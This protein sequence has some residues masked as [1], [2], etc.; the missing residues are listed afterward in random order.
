MMA[1]LTVSPT[2]YE[3]VDI[4]AK[5]INITYTCDKTLTDVKLSID[6]GSAY[7]NNDSM[8]QTSAMFNID[9]MANDDYICKLK[10]YYN[11]DQVPSIP[12][13][14]VALDKS[15]YTFTDYTT[16]Q[17][18][19]TVYP[20][21]A[22]NKNIT[23]SSSN[24]SV[25][26][27]NSDGLVT[28]V[29]NGNV[30]ITTTT[31]DGGKTSTCY[32]TVNKVSS[33]PVLSVALD[34]SS[35]TFTDYT[36]LQL[37]A[38]IYPS[39]ATNKNVSWT[40]SNSS[41]ATVDGSGLVTAKTNGNTTITVTTS[42]GDKTSTCSITVNKVVLDNKDI[43]LSSTSFTCKQGDT[44]ELPATTSFS[45]M[46]P[47]CELRKDGVR[48]SSA[49]YDRTA[50]KFLVYATSNIAIGTH[51]GVQVY[52][53]KYIDKQSDPQ[54]YVDIAWSQGFTLTITSKDGGG[55]GGT[56]IPVISVSLDVS[57]KSLSVGQGFTLYPTINPYD[58]TNKS[59]TWSTSNSGIASVNSSGYVYANTS[60]N[61]TITVTTADGYKTATCY[62]IVS[63]SGG[64]GSASIVLDM[65][66]ASSHQC[67]PNCPED[68]DWKYRPR[69]GHGSTL[70][71]MRCD[72]TSH[73]EYSNND[74]WKAFGQWVTVFKENGKSLVENVGV[75]L[76]DFKMW[77]YNNNTS[78]WILINDT[79]DYGA[80]Y[81]EDFWDDGNAPLPN[82]KVLSSDNKTY[83][84][85]MNGATSGRCFHPF[86]AQKYWR[87]HGFSETDNTSY[88]VSQVKFRLI[89]WDEYGVD[90][91]SNAHLTV[92]VGG[93]YWIYKGAEFDKDWRHN[94]DFAIGYYM[95][96]TNDWQTVYATS[97]PQSWD[98]GFPV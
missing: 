18:K 17:L 9:G 66:Y 84:C 27:V 32:V 21:D 59:V 45:E 46:Y 38:T 93:D 55:G 73:P 53:Q 28:A 92:D 88:V 49:S 42:D 57:S 64:G 3:V 36:T 54:G 31:V 82:N 7:K 87:D 60:G 41:V 23:W 75:E 97:C 98:K 5:T 76:T 68:I 61:A 40:S 22:T 48:L 81:L 89:K 13:L 15:S 29:A 37:Y 52:A 50:G 12:V 26:T 39:D 96:A 30:N 94:G 67:I 79:F 80:F 14:S 78:Q 58:A 4:N 1:T 6:N 70:P 51:E 77:R 91:R 65:Q 19:A 72:C 35:H 25:A 47:S 85:L 95:K 90:N 20:S 86:S 62:V 83:K 24:T 56:T 11:D 33:I 71:P 34:K 69:I 16:L 10:G 44:L 63:E 43:T 2:S 74:P 8:S